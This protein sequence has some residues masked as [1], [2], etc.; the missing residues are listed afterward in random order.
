MIRLAQIR[1]QARL[2]VRTGSHLVHQ[3]Q[4]GREA[5]RLARAGWRSTVTLRLPWLP[6]RLIDLLEKRL[7]PDMRVFEFGGGGSTL[8]FLDRELEVITVEHDAVWSSRLRES[9]SLPRWTLLVRSLDDDAAAYVGAID[10][11]PDDYFDLV[12]V[13][14]RERA[15]CV[16]AS[17]G[18]VRPGG[19]LVV[20]DVDRQRYARALEA[21][22][23]P[24]EDV[25]GFAPAKPS[26][27]Y[28]TL[29]TRPH[30]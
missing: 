15:R 24:R 21:V 12:V 2:L 23:W 29:F 1:H 19:M 28:S 8:W 17:L 10:D 22:D 18:K 30:E 13:D 11:Y 27:S 16:A 4:D 14:G 9:I 6:F 25:I 26:L 20:D 3:P 5:G 7:K